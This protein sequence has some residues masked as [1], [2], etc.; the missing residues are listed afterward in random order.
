MADE[1]TVANCDVASIADYCAKFGQELIDSVSARTAEF[2]EHDRIRATSY[3]ERINNLSELVGAQKLDLPKSHPDAFPVM[4]FPSAETVNG[5]E[6]TMVKTV[7][8]RFKALHTELLEGQSK[9]MSSGLHDADLVRIQAAVEAT[10][11]VVDFAE[12]TLDIPEN[13]GPNISTGKR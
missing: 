6:N 5:I 8:R 11:E 13:T 4:P 9:D 12:T 3:L 10:Q 1:T 7:V 2:S